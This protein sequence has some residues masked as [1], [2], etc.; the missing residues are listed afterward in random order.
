MYVSLFK[1][2]KIG[3]G[4]SSSHTVGPINASLQFVSLLDKNKIEIDSLK[5]N[6]FGSL[7]YTGKGHGTDMGIIAGLLGHRPNNVKIDE[8]LNEYSNIKQRQLISIPLIGDV[9]FNPINDI[10]FCKE[11][12]KVFKYSNAMEF[13]ADYGQNQ[14]FKRVFYSIGGGFV[15]SEDGKENNERKVDY[16][17]SNAADLLRICKKNNFLIHQLII[18]NEV[19]YNQ[20]SEDRVRNNILELW[21]VMNSSIYNGMQ[22]TGYLNGSLKIKRRANSLYKKLVKKNKGYDPL[23]VLDWVNIFAIAV[24]EENASFGRIVTAPTNGAAGI[25]PAVIKY[26]VEFVENSNEDGIVRFIATASAIGLL[27]KN[28]AS[29]SGAEAGCQGEV[30]VACSMAAAGLTAALNASNG[31]I[32]N[33]AE[34]A[35][36]HNLGLTCDPINGL[37]QIP[38]IERNAMGAIKAINASRIAINGSGEHKVS[39]D[40]VIATMWETGK[41]MSS[42]YKETSKGGLA[43]NVTE[44]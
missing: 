16:L 44:C 31:Q 17:F 40:E 19:V 5:I 9:N 3:I 22:N 23:D 36:E 8:I 2:F 37:V 11:N 35:M 21:K 27:Y 33:A 6:L 30:G 39:L 12:K 4:P 24:S 43:V 7:A 15:V 41:N 10:V 26:Y 38:C 20:L 42:I 29:I 13:I 25:I 34:I 28:N 32:E 1:L 18:K 14:T